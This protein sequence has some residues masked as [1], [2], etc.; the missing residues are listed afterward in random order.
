M[1][2]LKLHWDAA[3][4]G[5]RAVFEGLAPALSKHGFYLAGGTALALLEA[6]RISIDL[7]LFSPSFSDPD[8]VLGALETSS[9]LEVANVAVGRNAVD[10]EISG[11]RVSLIGC[12]YPMLGPVLELASGGLPVADRDDIAVMKL[13]AIT[14]RGSRKDFIDFW[15]LLDRHRTLPDYLDLFRRKYSR[16]DVGH[17]VRSLVYFADAEEDPP[18]KLL[19]P[20]S[21]DQVK[22][23]LRGAVASL[24]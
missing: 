8:A 19:E 11:I 6:H 15:L 12:R 4:P 14:N 3:A 2:G 21:W 5:M 10:L 16:R 23:D 13:S 17:V 24:L 20:I 7:D 9:T 22:A 18:L 1:A